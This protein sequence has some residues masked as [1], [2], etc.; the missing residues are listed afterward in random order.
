MKIGSF[1]I[2]AAATVVLFCAGWTTVAASI[3]ESNSLKAIAS[4]ADNRS[5]VLVNITNTLYASENTMGN[6]L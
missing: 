6:W 2:Q 3:V 1:F 4:Q 5:L